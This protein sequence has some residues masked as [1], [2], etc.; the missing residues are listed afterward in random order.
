[1]SSLGLVYG[2]GG[3]VYSCHYSPWLR[4]QNGQA[5]LS[6]FSTINSKLASRPPG[7]ARSPPAPADTTTALHGSAVSRPDIH[8]ADQ[9]AP[10]GQIIESY[11][12]QPDRFLQCTMTLDKGAHR[13]GPTSPGPTHAGGGRPRHP[14]GYTVSH[15][16]PAARNSEQNVNKYQHCEACLH[17]FASKC[18]LTQVRQIWKCKHVS[19]LCSFCSTL[20]RRS[21]IGSVDVRIQWA[22]L[23]TVG[24]SY[25]I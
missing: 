9:R 12:A 8:A 22:V 20:R 1:M 18:P 5:L 3:R 21:N 14:A 10:A 15:L 13:P 23:L 17:F 11:L 16:Q 4:F 6:R 24:R 25:I 2:L 19:A 7:Q